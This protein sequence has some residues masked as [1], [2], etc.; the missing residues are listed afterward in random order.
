MSTHATLTETVLHYL[1]F[2]LRTHPIITIT[3][4][5]TIRFFFRRHI[6]P[7]HKYPGPFLA[8]GTRLYSLYKTYH[9]QTHTDH[10][11]LHKKYGP[12]VRIQPN[13]L[14]F[15]SPEAARQVLAPGK[16]FTKTPFY[17]VFPPYGNPDIFTEI[18]EEV[19]AQKKR[20]VNTPYSLATFQALTPFIEQQ[21]VA[22]TKKLDSKIASANLKTST[23]DLGNL[24]HWFAFDV[25][26]EVAFS[27]PF[28]F[29]EQERDIE[30]TIKCIDN[31][32]VYDGVIGQIPWLDYILRRSFWWGRVPGTKSIAENH[33]TQTALKVLEQRMGGEVVDRKD[34]LSLLLESHK[35]DP[36]KFDMGTVFAVAHG[37]IAAGS[38]STASTMQSF[39]WNVLS[40][41]AVY[42]RLVKEVLEADKSGGL[43][44]VVKWDEAK[45]LKYFQACLKEAM[46]IAPA[47]GLAMYR[48]VPGLGVEIDGT[49]VPGGTEVAV[50]A[51][52]LHRDREIFGHDPDVF[53]PERWLGDEEKGEAKSKLMERFMFQVSEMISMRTY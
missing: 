41:G 3:V 1:T 43:S 42:E 24:L 33:V 16:G 29:L 28:G 22:L 35:K 27:K 47:V 2:L 23:T 17:W 45:E 48:K 18:R 37:A 11:A 39:M 5:I 7:L 9:G 51:W 36:E 10:I 8:S 14:S 38:D 4:L 26:G 32:Q 19:H 12:I 53:R 20:F 21:I 49:F 13:Q 15:S 40:K 30:G 31:V 25:L 46:R 44:E 34:L 52:V 6:S 50:N